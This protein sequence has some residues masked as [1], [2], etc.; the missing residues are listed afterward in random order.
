MLKNISS[1]ILHGG[2][3][4]HINFSLYNPYCTLVSSVIIIIIILIIIIIIM[5]YSQHIYRVL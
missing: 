3:H 2:Q 1:L 5:V 4:N